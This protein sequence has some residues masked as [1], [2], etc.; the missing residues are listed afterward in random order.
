MR[1]EYNW[2]TDPANAEAVKAM[3]W[4]DDEKNKWYI[5]IPV[6]L[7]ESSGKWCLGASSETEKL[8]GEHLT[9]FSIQSDSPEDAKTQ[10]FYMLRLISHHTYEEVL[11]YQRWV[12]FRRGAWNMGG[13]RWVTIFGINIYFRYGKNMQ[14]GWYIPFTKINIRISNEWKQ[15][16]RHKNK[17]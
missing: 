1:R 7:K 15:Y 5:Q 3:S 11:K 2:W 4:W 10:F 17:K 8:L 16:T 14:H 13:S 12:P 9:S 6:S